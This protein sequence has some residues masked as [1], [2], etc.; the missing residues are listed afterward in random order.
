M[1]KIYIFCDV[2]KDELEKDSSYSMMLSGF[3]KN[4][5]LKEILNLD[6]CE[7]C[8]KKIVGNLTKGK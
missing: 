2:C 1:R 4:P 8:F 5:L 7:E 3:Y 6:F